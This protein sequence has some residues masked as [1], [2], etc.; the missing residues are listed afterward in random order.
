MGNLQMD[1]GDVGA[2]FAE[3]VEI[4]GDAPPV[5]F[6]DLLR[7]VNPIV[8]APGDEGLVGRGEDEALV[9]GGDTDEFHPRGSASYQKR[10]DCQTKHDQ[11][12]TAKFMIQS[13][14]PSP[15]ED[16]F[17]VDECTIEVVLHHRG[18]HSWWS[19]V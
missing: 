2:H 17:A 18:G 14:Y 7:F 1:P 11:K 9:V 12:P 8:V 15:L 4:A 13:N 16:R 10:N 3:I 6:A 5:H 19:M